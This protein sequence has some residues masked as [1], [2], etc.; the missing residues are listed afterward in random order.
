MNRVLVDVDGTVGR[1][2]LNRPEVMNAIDTALATELEHA[3]RELD[4]EDDVHVIVV[5]GSGGNF[6]AG[7]D[8]Q[9]VRRL[10]ELG[11]Q[12]LDVL[13]AA[14]RSACTSIRDIDTPVIAVVEGVA[15]AGG[16]ELVQAVDIALVRDDARLSDN[17][18]NF[19]QIPGGGG[20][21]RLPRL[22]GKQR[23]LGHLLSGERLSGADAEQ[24]GLATRSFPAEEFES[25][26]EEFVQRVASKDALALRTIKRLVHDGFDLP[27][28]EGL[29]LEQRAV[30][31]HITGSDAFATFGERSAS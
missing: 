3:L 19:G 28:E 14:F 30:V 26:A 15:M 24:L 10:S 18:V 9:E 5:R 31:Q 25:S 7:G 21:Q 2:T 8:V 16:F 6:C 27:L 13:F 1:I 12:A 20:S 4:A 29:D 23:A 22:L 17:H 11:P